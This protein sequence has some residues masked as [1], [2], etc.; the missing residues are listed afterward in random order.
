MSLLDQIDPKQLQALAE[1]AGL[2]KDKVLS[3]AKS[4]LPTIKDKLGGLTGG[5]DTS[6]FQGLL[7]DAKFK[8]MF[9]GPELDAASA[10]VAKEHGVDPAAIKKMLPELGK[11]VS[12]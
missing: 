1:K 10:K 5:G 4:M 8:A 9:D 6:L 2:D 11:L 7:A 3:I 12:K